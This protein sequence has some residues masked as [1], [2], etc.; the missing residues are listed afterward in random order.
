MGAGKSTVGRL[1]A[2]R[3]K[4][5]FYDSDHVIEERTGVNIPTIFDIEGEEGFRDREE[6]VIHDLCQKQGII[7]ATGGGSLLREVNRESITNSG[8]VIYLRATPEQLYSRIRHDKNRPLM[9][10]DNPLKTLKD[11]LKKRETHYIDTA[12]IIANTGKHRI[13]HTVHQ[14]ERSLKQLEDFQ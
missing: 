6:Q 11:I 5:D 2:K 1:L 9:Q 4:T 12:D 10:T 7:L 8:I 13:I 14:I 3:L